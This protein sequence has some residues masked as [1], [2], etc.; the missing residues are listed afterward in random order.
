MVMKARFMLLCHGRVGTASLLESLQ[1]ID[2]VFVPSYWHTDPL[3]T[4]GNLES[5]LRNDTRL[6]EQSTLP[7]A[8]GDVALGLINHNFPTRRGDAEETCRSLHNLLAEGAPVFLWTRDPVENLMSSY[9]TYLATYFIFQV[10]EGNENAQGI[11][12]V[13]SSA[14]PFSF[15]E[16]VD[17]HHYI[18]DYE[19]QRALYSSAGHPVHM[20]PYHRLSTD[21][22]GEIEAVLRASGIGFGKPTISQVEY[23]RGD[24][25]AVQVSFAF[26]NKF[27]IDGLPLT[28]GYFNPIRAFPNQGTLTLEIQKNIFVAPDQ[29]FRIP[30]AYKRKIQTSLDP[31]QVIPITRENY[32]S[33]EQRIN[34]LVALKLVEENESLMPQIARQKLQEKSIRLD[35]S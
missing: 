3:M 34:T 19:A 23:P 30:R 5:L 21:L 32:A 35:F 22:Q 10:C 17:K 18:V 28:V 2:E 29:W 24:N 27:S 14:T 33:F 9:K 13:F 15:S 20:R 25:W 31:W 1:E 7:V 4:S 26:R 6:S 8:L 16:F 11:Y 12:Q